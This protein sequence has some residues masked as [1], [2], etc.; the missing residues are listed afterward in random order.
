MVLTRLRNLRISADM[1]RVRAGV[2][3]VADRLIG[4]FLMAQ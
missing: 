1:I 4:Q 2:D 3:H